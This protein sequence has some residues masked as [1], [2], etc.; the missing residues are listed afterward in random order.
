MS[1]VRLDVNTYTV[2]T[3]ARMVGVSVRTMHHYDAIGLV[4]PSQRSS[5]GYREYTDD[6]V[7]RL[8]RVLTYRGS[9]L[10]A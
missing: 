6:D 10:H 2:G 3:V 1:E 8:H 9:R 7:E 4:V 5:S